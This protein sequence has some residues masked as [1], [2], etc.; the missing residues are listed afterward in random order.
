MSPVVRMSVKMV[1][2]RRNGTALSSPGTTG[3]LEDYSTVA[4]ALHANKAF[5]VVAAD[6]LS[7]VELKPPSKFGVDAVVAA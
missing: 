5:M 3:S 2:E 7:L 4:K 1:A 6:P